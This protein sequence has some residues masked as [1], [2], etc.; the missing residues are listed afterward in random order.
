M[1]GMKFK[2][3]RVKVKTM[4]CNSCKDVV[5]PFLPSRSPFPLP[6]AYGIDGDL[7]WGGPHEI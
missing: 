2:N 1:H 7:S 5:I 4:G 3:G 6:E